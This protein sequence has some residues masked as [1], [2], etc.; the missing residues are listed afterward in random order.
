MREI[1]FRAWQSVLKNMDYSSQNFIGF[2]GKIYF[3]N[4]DLWRC[5]LLE[6]HLL[7]PLAQRRHSSF[8]YAKC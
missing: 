7:Y 6:L 3:G 5:L 4:A 1:K 2:D 8:C